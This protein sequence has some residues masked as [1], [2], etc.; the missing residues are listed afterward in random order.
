[1]FG[2]L[3]KHRMKLNKSGS[4]LGL[5]ISKKIIQSLGGKVSVESQ[6]GFGTNFEFTINAIEH[7]V[8]LREESKQAR[9]VD[10]VCW[11]LLMFFSCICLN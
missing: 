2:M 11:H 5:S 1:M 9:I 6:E 7:D 8:E 4:G 3:D 10:K